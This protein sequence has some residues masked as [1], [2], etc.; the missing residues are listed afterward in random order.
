MRKA[1]GTRQ[2]TEKPIA[3]KQPISKL[4]T[5]YSDDSLIR[6]RGVPGRYILIH[7]FS[8]LLNRPSDLKQKLVR[9]LF[10]RISVSDL[11]IIGAWIN[12]SSMYML[13]IIWYV[14]WTTLKDPIFYSN[15]L[16]N[17]THNEKK[18]LKVSVLFCYWDF[19]VLWIGMKFGGI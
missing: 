6:T 14:N 15:W 8:G 13:K 7:E 5:H 10:V 16:C 4:K 3:L 9:T 18:A 2:A 19:R 11:R 1:A 17:L 12:E